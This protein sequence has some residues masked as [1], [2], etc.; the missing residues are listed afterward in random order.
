MWVP[1]QILTPQKRVVL[2]DRDL[3][4]W[5]AQE[6]HEDYNLYC[7]IITLWKITKDINAHLSDQCAVLLYL[8]LRMG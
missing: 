4:K 2:E 1:S 6:Q 5:R 8:L 3:D 7:D